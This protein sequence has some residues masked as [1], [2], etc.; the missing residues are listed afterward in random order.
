[1][2]NTN[3]CDLCEQFAEY[4]L[5]LQDELAKLRERERSTEKIMEANARLAAEVEQLKE[6]NRVLVSDLQSAYRKAGMKP[7]PWYEEREQLQ[8]EIERLRAFVGAY[9]RAR[10]RTMHRPHHEWDR[11]TTWLDDEAS[12]LLGEKGGE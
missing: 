11:E 6:E 9:K 1:M 10:G 5:E 12:I 3:H 7:M 2:D 4:I 8:A